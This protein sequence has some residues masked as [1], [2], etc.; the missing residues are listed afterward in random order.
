MTEYDAEFLGIH[1][2]LPVFTPAR[3]GDILQ[4]PGLVNDELATFPNYGVTTDRRHRAPAFTV[5][6]ID[7][8]KKKTT[9]RAKTWKTDTRIGAE[10]QLDDSYFKDNPW[11]KGHM[12]DRESAGWG[13]TQREAQKS[14]DE[15]FYYANATLQHANLNEDEWRGV[16]SAILTLKIVKDGLL[17][18]FSGPVFGDNPRIVTPPGRTS[19]EVP[20]AFFKVVCFRN[21]TDGKLEVRSF[22]VYQDDDAI[23][24][25]HGRRTYNYT[26][27]QVTITEI[28]QL[29]GLDFP[30]EVYDANPLYYYDNRSAAANLNIHSFPERVDIATPGDIVH[31]DTPRIHNAD[32][33]IGVYLAAA[34]PKPAKKGGDEWVSLS[35]FETT[36]VDVT[37]WQLSDR[38][39]RTTTLKGTIPAVLL[40]DTG[41]LL[42]L[43]TRS[44]DRVDQAD[45]TKDEVKAS[46]K[47]GKVQP[48]IFLNYRTR[49]RPN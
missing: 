20:A 46:I 23:K 24:D 4:K 22:L 3:S 31:H 40:P 41:G 28:E 45:Y 34:L 1:L 16:E 5:L 25:R 9:K 15:T 44:G 12:A 35:N 49:L 13:S 6:H 26:H 29:T 32:D 37:G 42:T 2:P 18:V 33:E 7:Q 43:K 21:A 10:F 14:A 11:D 36:P 39:S 47:K 48:I 27:Y 17:T 8:K 38:R 30:N 19:A